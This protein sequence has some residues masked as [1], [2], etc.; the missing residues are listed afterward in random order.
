MKQRFQPGDTIT[1]KQDLDMMSIYTKK[2]VPRRI[3]YGF[4]YTVNEYTD[5]IKGE[6]WFLTL[7]EIPGVEFA[8]VDFAKI[9]ERLVSSRTEFIL[10][11]N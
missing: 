3:T 10:N 4:P 5:Y 11:L 7:V 1:L 2:K 6:G 9:V 8:E